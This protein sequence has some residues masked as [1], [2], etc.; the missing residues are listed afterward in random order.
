M[1]TEAFG[2]VLPETVT[3]SLFVSDSSSG[4]VRLRV[5]EEEEGVGAIEVAGT[6]DGVGVFWGSCLR[7]L[8]AVQIP[9]VMIM[10]IIKPILMAR[11]TSFF[12][13]GLEIN[14]RSWYCQEYVLATYI[15]NGGAPFSWCRVTYWSGVW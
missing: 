7:D 13:V 11:N 5:T 2:K 14:N 12:M 6:G 3:E 15:E 4:E 1:V 8:F 9:K 10:P